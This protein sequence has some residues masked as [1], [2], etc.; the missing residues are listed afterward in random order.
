LNRI[1]LIEDVLGYKTYRSSDIIINQLKFISDVED[2]L[3]KIKTKFGIVDSTKFYSF[4][5]IFNLTSG[6]IEFYKLLS[7]L[8]YIIKEY[9]KVDEPLW[10]QCWVNSHSPEG[11]LKKHN[12]INSSCHGYISIRPHE[13]NT[14]F[15]NYII[16][17]DIGKIYIGPS[18]RMHWVDVLE[19]FDLKRIT[20]GYDVFNESNMLKLKHQ[21]GN[22]INISIMPI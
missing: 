22:D 1:S 11:V 10:M 20:L 6:S 14:V 13:T 15:D 5:N 19:N 16:K 2:S 8:K 12:H 18:D 3:D 21:Y 9:H 4:Y 17:N 7:D